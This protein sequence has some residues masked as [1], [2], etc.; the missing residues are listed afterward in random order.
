MNYKQWESMGEK[1]SFLGPK[2]SKNL[3]RAEKIEKLLQIN[4]ADVTNLQYFC[5]LKK[6][7]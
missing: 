3:N 2:V 5:A 4:S 6:I 1:S 7:V